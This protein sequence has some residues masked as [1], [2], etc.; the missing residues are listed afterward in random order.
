MPHRPHPVLS[1]LAL[2]AVSAS[3]V[4]AQTA[5]DG[6]IG[7]TVSDTS[8]AVL[9]HAQVVVHSNAT[10]TDRTTMTDDS[11]S[12]LVP[13]LG[14]GAYTVTVT[15]AGFETY[16]SQNVAVQ[17]GLTTN[18]PAQLSPGS[19]TQ[20]VQ[21]SGATPSLNTTNNDFSAEIGLKVLEDLPVNNYRWS[22]Y[23]LLTP[24]V[25]SDA[26]GFGLLSFRGQSTLL[27]NITF[28]GADDNQKFFS[29][30]RGR[31]RAGYSTSKWVVD[32]FQVNTSNYS[33]EY[34]RAAGGVVNAVSKSG[35]N[36][37]HGEGYFF[38]RDS[39]WSAFNNFT[40]LTTPNGNG[41]FT[42]RPFKTPEVRRQYGFEVGGPILKDRLFFL[43][44]ADKFSHGFPGVSVP[45][46]PSNFYGAPRATDIQ[47]LATTLGVSQAQAAADYNN[48]VAGLNSIL[49]VTPRYG[50][51]TIYFPK[52][53]W[54]VDA[55]NHV[56][57]EYNRLNW[58]SPAGIQTA[59]GGINYGVR[60]YGNDDA[61]VNWGIAKLDT[62]FTPRLSNE[63]RYQYGRDF[64][65]EFNQQPTAYEQN[66]LLQ[67]PAGYSNP[68]NGIPPNVN[69]QNAFQFGT[70]TFLNRPA[71]PDER[72]W[73]AT[74]T[75]Q[76][77]HGN[78]SIKFGADFVHTYDLSENLTS[79]FG[80]YTYGGGGNAGLLGYVEDYYLSQNPATASQ[81]THYTNYSQGFGTL[82][83]QFTTVDY[84]GFAQDEWKVAPR[85][86][87]TYGLRYEYEQLPK[88]QLPN[89]TNPNPLISLAQT[90]NLPDNR[91]NVAP[92]VGFA[93]Q[94]SRDGKTSIR[95]G[96]GV[97][98][99]RLINSTIYNA[100]AQTG[101]LSNGANGVPNAQL[102]FA[103]TPTTPGRPTFPNVIPSAGRAG[104]PPAAIY[105]DRNFKLPQVQQFDLAVEHQFSTNTVVRVSWLAALGRR[106]PDF[107][108]QNLSGN[109][110]S[111]T[112]TVVDPTG[113][114][115]LRN[116]AR[117]Q[118]PFYA[119]T[120]NQ[121]VTLANG[122]TAGNF[123]GNPYYGSLTNIF[124]GVNSDYE[125]GVVEVSQR[126]TH[127]LTFNANYT[128]SHA[129]D[130]GENNTTFTN[131]S[132]QYDPTDLRADY[133]N[134]NQNVP[135]RL[136]L[137]GIYN[138]P[139]HFHG[140]LGYALNNYEIAPDYQIQSGLPYSAGTTGSTTGL[141][142]D[143]GATVTGIS[144]SLNG[145]DG[146]ARI[147]FVARNYAQFPRTQVV[148]LRL[149]K[150][151]QV[152]EGY[153]LELLGEGFNLANHQNVTALNTTAY[154]VGTTPGTGNTLTF[155]TQG[156]VNGAPATPAYQVVTNSNSNGFTYTPRQLQ[157]SARFQF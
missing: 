34:G 155:N 151:F 84:A 14:S 133:G 118:T 47:A 123:R 78:H 128:F 92:R 82:G 77:V 111:V 28:D 130:Y 86:S 106:L 69:I 154:T 52:L 89:S 65:F 62:L 15:Q 131:T 144:T 57:G 135:H 79:A 96:Y 37:F 56:S 110:Q 94:P 25:V 116:G 156:G 11:G 87:L 9:G 27:N 71:Y 40:N 75:I 85:L 26:N 73:Q 108:D 81:A 114:G 20:T 31:T 126:L 150:R 117:Y 44:A 105:F 32:E 38:Y 6:A 147:P 76:Y 113:R 51:Q 64:E 124:S 29:E 53:D 139:S 99:A 33:T 21:V 120:A 109:V 54:Q 125:G 132:N 152:H 1:T 101:V 49:G 63:V 68:F 61:R 35:T 50:D 157:L 13:Q 10:G 134:S 66:T 149:S 100:I 36:Q 30:E 4:L 23:A 41:T 91:T 93:F 22:S 42:T 146:P 90:A 119:R 16:T 80:G 72:A 59:P 18:L 148:D 2:A 60:S 102:Q 153:T 97:F 19:E 48:A 5:T 3:P 104:T 83:F 136:V 95:G 141:L 142:S 122:V 103:Y 140:L 46:N 58:N 67:T 121:N 88:P 115:P 12:F 129:L 17:V 143:A 145:T 45:S 24:G 112:Y 127:G 137:Y 8:G 98:Y 138:S 39:N 74:D 43:V 55:K 70:A 107:V 7:G